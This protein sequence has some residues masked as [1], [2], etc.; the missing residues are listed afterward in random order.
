MVLSDCADPDRHNEND[1][2]ARERALHSRSQQPAAV[3]AFSSHSVC[4][5]LL[6]AQNYAGHKIAALTNTRSTDATDRR[7]SKQSRVFVPRAP[8]AARRPTRLLSFPLLFLFFFFLMRRYVTGTA[9]TIDRGRGELE[10]DHS[11]RI[12]RCSN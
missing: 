5:I 11:L 6:F 9:I 7:R 12:N 2:S 1:R 10:R 4:T 8:R 3:T